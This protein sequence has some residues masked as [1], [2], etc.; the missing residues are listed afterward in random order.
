MDP[1]DDHGEEDLGVK[2]STFEDFLRRTGF[3]MS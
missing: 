1:G 2:A 3:R